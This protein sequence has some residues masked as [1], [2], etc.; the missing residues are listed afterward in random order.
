MPVR[1]V[2]LSSR[3]EPNKFNRVI[4]FQYCSGYQ[5]LVTVGASHVPTHQ[6]PISTLVYNITNSDNSSIIEGVC[7]KNLEATLLF[8][9]FSKAFDSMHREKMDQILLAYKLPKETVTAIIMLYKNTKAM[10]CSPDSDTD[11]FEIFV[12]ILQGNV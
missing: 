5:L 1:T 2:E 9:E 12:G 6:D 3:S 11:L 7:T 8:V 4:T 10:V